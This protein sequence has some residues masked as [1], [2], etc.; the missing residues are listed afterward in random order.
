MKKAGPDVAV[1]WA[2]DNMRRADDI[3]YGL[4]DCY[5]FL[6]KNKKLYWEWLEKNGY[7]PTIY[8]QTL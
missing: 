8:D 2:W 6:H 1:K 5:S 3:W 4:A 7:T